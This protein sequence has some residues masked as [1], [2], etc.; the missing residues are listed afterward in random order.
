MIN[1][2][3]GYVTAALSLTFLFAGAPA[4]AAGFPERPAR[5]VV[6][7]AA[8][9]GADRTARMLGT[10]LAEKWGQPVI[11]QN[12]PGVGGVIG[13]EYVARAT[14][15]GYTLLLTGNA[16][17]VT[18]HQMKV[19]YHPINDFEPVTQ[20][21]IQPSILLINPAV[22]ARSVKELVALAKAKPGQLNY[23]TTGGG[24]PTNLQMLL[25]M[26]HQGFTMTPVQYK[27]GAAAVL[28]MLG[29]EVQ[30]TFFSASGA[31]P[32]MDAGKVRALAITSPRRSPLFADVPT[33]AEALG[34]TRYEGTDVWHGVVAPKGTAAAI[35]NLIRNAAVEVMATPDFRK[36][37]VPIGF[38]AV[39]STP[40]EFG[41]FLRAD[42]A[43]W[44]ALLKGAGS[45]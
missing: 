17:T 43:K 33:L 27:S 34:L 12:R 16:H 22:A 11:I 21:G 1:S 31:R 44:P 26:N 19:P 32:H 41:E 10:G 39:G 7:F 6:G 25:L 28:A 36:A 18:P 40:K 42:F 30:V 3:R 14:P 13:T 38:E 9:G 35:V 45:K 24:S 23:S 2:F 20:L 29:G 15:D 4:T 37:T 8:G 5:I